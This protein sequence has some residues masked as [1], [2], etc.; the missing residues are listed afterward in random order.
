MENL[1]NVEPVEDFNW[2]AYENE[3]TLGGDSHEEI[4]KD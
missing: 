1:K 2:D 3:E 4:E